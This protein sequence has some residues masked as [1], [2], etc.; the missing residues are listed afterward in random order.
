ME[1]SR[2][3]DLI[4]RY[5]YVFPDKEDALAG[6]E[7][8]FWTKYSSKD[9]VNNASLVSY[10]LLAMG[11]KKGNRIAT[12]CN[13]RP[14]WNFL[15]MGM[16]QAG[17]VHL[18]IYPT[19]SAE[20]FTYILNHAEPSLVIV[21]DKILH[22]KI[23]PIIR[24]IPA[25]KDIYSF[26]EIENVK[27]W[28]EILKLGEENKDKLSE[29]LEEIKK[30]I[31]TD[32]LA[33]II[34]TSGTTGNPKGVMLSNKN[35]IS[36][37]RSISQVFDFN[38]GH[39]TLSFLPVSHVF[40]R[41]IDYYFQH[42]GVSIYY[43]E[44]LGTIS[45]NL[46]EIK[47][48]VFIS[49][50]RLLE[51]VYDRIIGKGKDL[52][53]IKKHLFFWAVNLGLK[54]EFNNKNGW[55]YN[56]R[57]KIA[58]KLI[59]SKWKEALGNNIEIIVAGGAAL[60]TRLSRV[61]NAA[62]IPVVEGYGMTE[63]SPVIATNW[64]PKKAEVRI[65]TVGPA[66]PGV[67]VKIAEDGEILC[68]GDNIM[69]GYYKEPELTKEIIDDE[70][71]LHTGD[72]GMLEDGRFLRITDRKKEMF[73]LSS[74]KYVAPQPIENKLK[75]SFFI[76]QAMVIGENEKFASALILPNFP[77]LHNWCTIH[78]VKYRD[79]TELIQTPEVVNRFQR[80]V[81][82]INK[83][84]GLTE[85]IKRFR[86]V[87]DEWSPQTGELSPTLKVKRKYIAEKYKTIIAEIYSVQKSTGINED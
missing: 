82:E 35:I 6:K 57:L 52:K 61:Y 10:G 76:E 78:G 34:Y 22:D 51:R 1:V 50:P 80:E 75:E 62:G 48:H 79:N 66:V 27:N 55:F 47:P 39:R 20:D 25:V 36:N 15:D 63:S 43:A 17:I 7:K 59:F 38:P 2:I 69:M 21:S 4:D 28:K 23:E 87:I 8:G 64:P 56:L 81:T 86:L 46:R 85:Q 40:E 18:P 71:W 67:E 14:E 13:N 72:I 74:G 30:G 37:V 11:F 60:Q 19:I 42:Q 58:G 83:Q 29:T 84:L 16:A 77:F 41:T 33:T 12:I 65:G 3:C 53:G 73:K 24:K 5:K 26:N 68:K 31:L 44:N 45:D 49:V 54:Y 9:Y 32:D 70:G